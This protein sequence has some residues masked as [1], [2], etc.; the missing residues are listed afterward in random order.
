[1][2]W[3]LTVPTP[4]NVIRFIPKSDPMVAEVRDVSPSAG[5]SMGRRSFARRCWLCATVTEAMARY[6]FS[7]KYFTWLSRSIC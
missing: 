5:T 1:M 3:W 2:L 4:R 6:C 7:M